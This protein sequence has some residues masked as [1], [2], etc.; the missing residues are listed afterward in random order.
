MEI[1]CIKHLAASLVDPY[2]L[3]DGLAAGAAAIPTGATV[4]F[5]M[6]A[7]IADAGVVAK[8]AGLAM[9]NRIGGG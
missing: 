5:D 6:P 8:L 2:L 7:V 1:P 3:E 9:R 4:E